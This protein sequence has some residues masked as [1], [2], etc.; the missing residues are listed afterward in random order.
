[1]QQI[2]ANELK[3]QGVS[4][5]AEALANSNEAFISIR[6]KQKYVVLDLDY[7]QKLREAELE[8]AIAETKA[9][10]AAGKFVH[11]TPE[12]HLAR[13]EKLNLSEN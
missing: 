6:G 11:E 3:V 7:Y 5:I 2:S 9:E 12:E 8:A 4:A 1:M 13:I 10:Y